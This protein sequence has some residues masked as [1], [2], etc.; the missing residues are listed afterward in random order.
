[1]NGKTDQ[2]KIL[3]SYHKDSEIV[4]S[5]IMTPIQVGAKNSKVDLNILRDDEGVNISNKNARYCELTAQYWAWKNIEA[6]FY[7]FMHY[8]RHFVFDD[9]AHSQDKRAFL[10]Y[11]R[12]HET[13]KEEIGLQD[14]EIRRCL[15]DVDI[16]LPLVEDTSDWGAVSN[17]VQFSCLEN[18]HAA[19]FDMVCRTVTELY[20]DYF[21][22]VQEFRTGHYAYWYNMFVMK[23]EIF[24]DYCR[25]LFPVLEVSEKKIDFA[26]YN[27]QET[28]TLAFMAERLLSIYLIKLFKD[29]PL[30]RVKFLKMTFIV[31]TDKFPGKNAEAAVNA[32]KGN[33]KASYV[34]SVEKAYRE[35]KDL[36]LPYD[37]DNLLKVDGDKIEK[38]LSEKKM[39]FYG[40]GNW[41][42]QLLWYFDRLGLDY[43][44]EIWDEAAN[45]NQRIGGVSMRKP[46]FLSLSGRPDAFWV[47]TI[48]NRAISD[49]VKELLIRQGAADVL[50]NREFV[51]W[52]SYRLWLDV[53]GR[54]PA[55]HGRGAGETRT[56]KEAQK[57]VRSLGCGR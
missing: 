52:L 20:P 49:G 41:C 13:Y 43:P 47:I 46:D 23:K 36:S 6:D 56:G 7:G 57:N 30:L 22:A 2:I 54:I 14:D 3:I 21:D 12:I 19:D 39:I 4:E 37:M 26:K 38:L 53:T 32:E 27:P 25:W 10:W 11:E 55:D 31:N 45:E 34:S 50:D 24:M 42:R 1:M 44:V 9:A 28:R 8:R 18:L 35:L 16:V 33:A 48:R 29:R 15:K 5:E 40:G 17:E 51:G